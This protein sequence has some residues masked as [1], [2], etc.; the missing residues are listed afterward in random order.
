MRVV[1]SEIGS[2]RAWQW[3][4]PPP[5]RGIACSR[6]ATRTSPCA[7]A[8]MGIAVGRSSWERTARGRR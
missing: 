6:R 8:A 4:P 5:F 3:A 2:G 1:T 7:P